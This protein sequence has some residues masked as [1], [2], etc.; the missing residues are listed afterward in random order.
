MKEITAFHPNDAIHPAFGEALREAN[1]AGV[2]ILAFDCN[3][4]KD[5]IELDKP[6]VVQYD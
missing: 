1:Q 3:V 4:T 2:K 5:S 6:V